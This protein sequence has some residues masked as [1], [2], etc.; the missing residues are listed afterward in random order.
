MYKRI[1]PKI[2]IMIALSACS[3]PHRIGVTCPQLIIKYEASAVGLTGNRVGSFSIHNAGLESVQFASEGV[4]EV[5]HG[6][7]VTIEESEANSQNWRPY[8][9][10]LEELLSPEGHIVIQPGETKFVKFDAN[11][12][13]I[14]GQSDPGMQ[15]SIVVRSIVGCIYR[16]EAFTYVDE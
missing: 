11:G 9:P 3:S 7:F 13:F 4:D 2:L 15:Y 8:N 5:L 16:S 6:R 14:P 1:F 10:V 12:L